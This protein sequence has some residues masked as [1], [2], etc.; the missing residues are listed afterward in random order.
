MIVVDSWKTARREC[1]QGFLTR[2]YGE[3]FCEALEKRRIPELPTR[4][5]KISNKPS[6]SFPSDVHTMSTSCD[7]T[8]NAAEKRRPAIFFGG[9]REKFRISIIEER[10]SS[11]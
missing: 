2:V 10:P 8:K 5:A 9:P 11:V 7:G 6:A 3:F 4:I 1:R